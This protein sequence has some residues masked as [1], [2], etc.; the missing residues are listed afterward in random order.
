MRGK[1]EQSKI[2]SPV[3][4]TRPD[5]L[6]GLR[7]KLVVALI[8]VILGERHA[9]AAIPAREKK[10]FGCSTRCLHIRY[11]EE[12]DFTDQGPKLSDTDP[13]RKLKNIPLSE[14]W[15]LDI[16]G[17]FRLKW[18]SRSN[19]DFGFARRTQ[20]AQQ[21]YRWFLN[22]NIRYRNLF[23]V[24]V[25]G[26]FNH[27]EDQDGPF[28][29]TRENHGDLQQL[30]FDLRF[31]GE[32]VPVNLRVGRQEL[33]YGANRL[34]GPLDWLSNRR[35][36]DAVKLIFRGE[37]WQLDAFYAK[38]VLVL[39]KS[40]DRWNEEFDLYG[41]YLNYRWFPEHEVELF[42]FAVDRTEDVTN[43]NGRSGDQSI[44]TFGG[45]FFGTW[46]NWDYDSELSGQWGTWAGDTVQAYDL[47]V[48]GGYTFVSV[49]WRPR[50]SAG[51]EWATGDDDP[52]DRSVETFTQLFPFDHQCIGMQDF[53]G[54]QNLT[55]A[56]VGLDVWPIIDKLKTSMAF[57]HFWLSEE[58][59]ALYNAGGVPVLRDK[60]GRSGVEFG[61]EMD[62]WLEWMLT[63]SS[64]FSLGYSHFWDDNFVHNLVREDDD[65]DMFIVQYR[66]RF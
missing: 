8:G 54:H 63:P 7:G 59:D 10:E 61:Q 43:P 33:N 2:A 27:V 45:R 26:A 58:S 18:E 9:N 65:P 42:T 38:P 46:G 15:K 64:T 14:S 60:K 34:I 25:Q 19:P 29:S 3:A 56:M 49:P 11:E 44:F 12:F 20:N 24:F 50:L 51:F 66:Y 6:R 21:D 16:G 62:I 52:N 1:H 22:T 32:D 30:F 35:R 17:E 37:K 57:S 55:R 23:R 36:F 47:N 39:R 48:E 13:R 53:V 41:I 28:Q 40:S 31:L 5:R 4:P